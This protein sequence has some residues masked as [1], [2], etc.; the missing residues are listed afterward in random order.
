MIDDH[1]QNRFA[2]VIKIVRFNLRFYLLS[3]AAISVA[4][5]LIASRELT[6]PFEATVLI[7]AA[8]V[9]FW[10]NSSLFV[11]W[12]VYDYKRVT[13][14]RWLP[15]RLPFKPQRWVNIHAGLDEST[16]A[17]RHLLPGT[18]GSVVDIYD[19]KEMTEPS[20]ARARLLHPADEPFEQ[21]AYNNLPL[22]VNSSDTVF[23]LFSA[24]EVRDAIHR[25]YLLREAARVLR[26]KGC[27]VLVEHLR[28][29]KNF[30]AFGPGF[31]HFFSR[32][33]WLRTIHDAGLLVVQEEA[34]TPFVRCFVLRRK[35][36]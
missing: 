24:H 28:D 18:Q 35:D 1:A 6:A 3:A 8:P 16:S 9:A 5:L 30:V 20:I 4:I 2:G 33:D 15:S 19:S 29:W 21:G 23:L 17:L 14:W 34:A 10:T 31:F 32:Q 7:V 22:L 27:V 36:L 25:M 26:D 11:S 13:Q 12:Y